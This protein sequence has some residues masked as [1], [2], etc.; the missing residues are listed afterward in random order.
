MLKN[1]IQIESLKNISANSSIFLG[2]MLLVL[3][4]L[5]NYFFKNFI[6]L[7]FLMCALFETQNMFENYSTSS[8]V[9]VVGNAIQLI[10]IYLKLFIA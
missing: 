7:Y 8:E 3:K 4:A 1:C 10:H 6:I 5:K 9:V 2:F